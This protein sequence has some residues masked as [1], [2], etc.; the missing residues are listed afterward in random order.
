MCTQVTNNRYRVKIFYR[1][2][3]YTHYCSVWNIILSSLYQKCMIWAQ[4]V[5]SIT[6]N[7]QPNFPNKETIETCDQFQSTK[8]EKAPKKKRPISKAVKLKQ[9]KAL[10]FHVITQSLTNM[11]GYWDQTNSH[12][13]APHPV[14]FERWEWA[15]YSEFTKHFFIRARSCFWPQYGAFNR[16]FVRF[17][18]W[19]VCHIDSVSAKLF[20]IEALVFVVDW[21]LL[22]IPSESW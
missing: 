11:E 7:H 21:N 1:K 10:K 8:T 19:F 3:R 5:K 22:K 18:S 15:N 16:S 14:K 13:Q 9:E 2:P 20:A 4:R 12:A 17:V 6:W